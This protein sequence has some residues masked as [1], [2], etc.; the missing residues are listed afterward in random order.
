MYG[1]LR[2]LLGEESANIIRDMMVSAGNRDSGIIAT[3]LGSVLLMFAATSVF[4]QLQDTL[5]SIWKVKPKPMN[6]I[7]AFLRQRVLSASMVMGIGFL[8][9]VSLLLSTALSALG[10]YFGHRFHGWD[11]LW[12][13]INQLVSL[14]V[15]TLLFAMI[16][17]VLPDTKVAWKDVWLGALV[18]SALFAIGK[19]LIGL[20]LSR[21]SV[22]SSYGAAG[23]FAVILIWVYYSSQILF[24]GAEFTHVYAESRGTRRTWKDGKPTEARD[25]DEQKKDEQKKDE[26]APVERL[27]PA[28]T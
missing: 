21:A 8:L 1:Q 20:Y 18:T 12:Q 13:G 19:L 25:M 16:Y 27:T 24:L 6:G 26:P 7:L 3:V 2:G 9:L 17:K 11:L 5:N 23:S 28:P 22:A 14:G 15:I 4:A 10:K